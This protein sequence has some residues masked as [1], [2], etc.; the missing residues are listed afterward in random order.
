MVWTNG[1]HL[2]TDI[3]GV[4][5]YVGP[6]MFRSIQI[7]RVPVS[8]IIRFSDIGLASD[9]VSNLCPHKRGITKYPARLGQTFAR[10][11]HSDHRVTLRGG[12]V[13]NAVQNGV[14]THT[15]TSDIREI[16]RGCAQMFVPRC[17]PAPHTRARAKSVSLR[18][19]Q[20]QI[21]QQATGGRLHRTAT[22]RYT[23]GRG[24]LRL[25]RGRAGA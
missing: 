23:S 7:A 15:C 13:D 10:T 22:V 5:V 16:L 1:S 3:T 4:C 6:M 17:P 21:F 12:N 25:L 11:P 18:A 14:F 20:S 8:K 24:C 2:S 19:I 9:Q